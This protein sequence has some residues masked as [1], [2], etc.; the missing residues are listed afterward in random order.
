MSFFEKAF[1]AVLGLVGMELT[2]EKPRTSRRLTQAEKNKYER[3]LARKTLRLRVIVLYAKFLGNEKAIR[4]IER[5]MTMRKNP[6]FVER[7][8][9]W[10]E[11]YLR[12]KNKNRKAIVKE[13]H[14]H[15]DYPISVEFRGTVVSKVHTH[16]GEQMTYGRFL[17]AIEKGE[18]P[19]YTI[20]TTDWDRFPVRVPWAGMIE[21]MLGLGK[22]PNAKFAYRLMA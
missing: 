14:K 9:S 15:I 10:I 13:L 3:K 11:G 12:I 22:N 18:F 21:E 5:T 1:N 7:Q 6:G 2:E 16:K 20:R 19:M 17:N 8:A 4:E